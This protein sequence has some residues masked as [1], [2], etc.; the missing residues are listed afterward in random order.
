MSTWVK[1]PVKEVEKK[2]EHVICDLTVLRYELLREQRFEDALLVSRVIAIV[3][4][5]GVKSDAR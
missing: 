2:E 1:I 3:K 4:V 5:R